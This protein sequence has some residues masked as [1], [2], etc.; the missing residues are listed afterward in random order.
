MVMA[1]GHVSNGK[2]RTW[3][4]AQDLCQFL[5]CYFHPLTGTRSFLGA[6]AKLPKKATVMLHVCPF[7]RLKQFSSHRTDFYEILYVEYCLKIRR[8]SSSFE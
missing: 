6:F 8:K 5:R 3:D 4:C 1:G 7:V 2:I